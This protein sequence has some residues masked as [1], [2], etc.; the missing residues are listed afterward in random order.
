MPYCLT[1]T[2]GKTQHSSAIF[3]QIFPSWPSQVWK[4]RTEVAPLCVKTRVDLSHLELQIQVLPV[5]RSVE[6][7]GVTTEDKSLT[8]RRQLSH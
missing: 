3:T 6:S 1:L 4:K 7:E 2:H 5:L 8:K